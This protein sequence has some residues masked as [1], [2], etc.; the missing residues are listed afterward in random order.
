MET[1]QCNKCKQIKPL[2]KEYFYTQKRPSRNGKIYYG[3]RYICKP[4]EH[5]ATLERRK[6][7]GWANEK[8]RQGPGSTHR[9][10]SKKNSQR[11]RDIMS[12]MYIRSLMTKK[13]KTLKPKDISQRLVNMHRISLQ[14]KRELRAIK[15]KER[16][17]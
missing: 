6:A 8:K 16:N 2:T 1:K 15:R 11:H 4:C 9:K 17:E 10:L 5:K 12:D 3:W 14:L 13:S 7:G